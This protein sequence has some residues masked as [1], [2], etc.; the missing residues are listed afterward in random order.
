MASTTPSEAKA[1]AAKHPQTATVPRRTYYLPGLSSL[2]RRNLEELCEAWGLHTQGLTVP[3]IRDVLYQADYNLYQVGYVMDQPLPPRAQWEPAQVPADQ[4]EKDRGYYN[5]NKTS[6]TSTSPSAAPNATTRATKGTAW[7]TKA[8]ARATTPTTK[9]AKD[10]N[11]PAEAAPDK[12]ENCNE[13]GSDGDDDNSFE[14][15][16]WSSP[17]CP[18]SPSAC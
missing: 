8:T 5:T 18:S 17:G 3:Q 6:S 13:S 16:K 7:A 10:A 12:K 14:K 11:I 9:T 2:A 1:K 15:V 4:E